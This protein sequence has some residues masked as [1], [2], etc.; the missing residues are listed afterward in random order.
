MYREYAAHIELAHVYSYPVVL[1]NAQVTYVRVKD[2]EIY[3]GGEN[4]TNFMQHD[5]IVL[6]ENPSDEYFDASLIWG[7]VF[8]RMGY[9]GMRWTLK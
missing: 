6:A 5:A 3:V 7:P 4:L 9:V 2:F 8:G 1:I